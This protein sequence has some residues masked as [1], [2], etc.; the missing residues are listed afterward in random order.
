MGRLAAEPQL[1]THWVWLPAVVTL[2]CPLSTIPPL[3]EG[4]PWFCLMRTP[5]PTP[6]RTTHPPASRMCMGLASGGFLGLT[7]RCL[8]KRPP[9]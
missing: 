8:G 3:R 1:G 4:I 9:S 6:L 7:D 5:S 2:P